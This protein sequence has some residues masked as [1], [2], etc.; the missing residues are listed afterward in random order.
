M[1]RLTLNF[2]HGGNFVHNGCSC[3]YIGGQLRYIDIQ[4]L[5]KFSYFEL[6]KEVMKLLLGLDP[7]SYQIAQR[8][9]LNF[10]RDIQP[11]GSI[12]SSKSKNPFHRRERNSY[13]CIFQPA[14]V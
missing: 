13:L 6:E 7:T 5:D 12:G 11:K 14:L 8:K 10:D 4:N 9:N 3:S 2:H 1:D